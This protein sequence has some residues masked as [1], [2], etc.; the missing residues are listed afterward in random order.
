MRN[1][2]QL[3]NQNRQL[4]HMLVTNAID[5]LQRLT[6]LSASQC[7]QLIRQQFS[8]KASPSKVVNHQ[9]IDFISSLFA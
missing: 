5:Q 1:Q 7:E 9:E 8:K 6:D 2:S 3:S 4:A